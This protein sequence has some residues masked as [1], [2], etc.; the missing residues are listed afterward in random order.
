MTNYGSASIYTND[1]L[2]ENLPNLID[3]DKTLT[4]GHNFVV[5][6]EP[7]Q[8]TAAD[9]ESPRDH[10]RAG[11]HASESGQSGLEHLP[12][13]AARPVLKRDGQLCRGL[14]ELARPPQ[15]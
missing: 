1:L 9:R 5:T 10:P 11:T 4:L 2:T 12:A 7:E 15:S 8:C 14:Y 3:R 13:G 6:P